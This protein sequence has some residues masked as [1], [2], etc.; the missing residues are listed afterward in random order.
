MDTKAILAA[1]HA[2]FR[3]AWHAVGASDAG[4]RGNFMF[5]MFALTF[6]EW[7]GRAIQDDRPARA[8]FAEFTP[9]S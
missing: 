5:A 1:F 8:K 6:F 7:C 4:G 9:R 3:D 2:D